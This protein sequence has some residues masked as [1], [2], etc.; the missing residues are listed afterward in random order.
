MRS[1]FFTITKYLV[2]V[3]IVVYCFVCCLFFSYVEDLAELVVR[4]EDDIAQL[5][6]QG[7][8]VRK[9]AATEMNHSSSRY[10]PVWLNLFSPSQVGLLS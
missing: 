7:N 10:C 3:D 9:M 4:N 6:E 8:K 1:I 2:C 5:Q